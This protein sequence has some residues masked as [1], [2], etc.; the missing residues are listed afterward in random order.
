[1]KQ[2]VRAASA[3]LPSLL[4]MKMVWARARC[5]GGSRSV[6]AR[7]QDARCRTAA[8]GQFRTTSCRRPPQIPVLKARRRAAGVAAE[9]LDRVAPAFS[10]GP[11]PPGTDDVLQ[12]RPRACKVHRQPFRNR[13]TGILPL[14][15]DARRRLVGAQKN[16]VEHSPV[17]RCGLGTVAAREDGDVCGR[18]R[19]VRGQIFRRRASCRCRRRSGCQSR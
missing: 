1:M 6:A 17:Q 4:V 12:V 10:R 19:A 13:A 18:R 3:V 16:S 11:C 5:D 2:C 7:E 15:H 14:G 9:F 8:G